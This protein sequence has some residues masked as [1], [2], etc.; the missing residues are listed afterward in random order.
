M[1]DLE[2]KNIFHTTAGL[3]HNNT[4][5]H[6]AGVVATANHSDNKTRCDIFMT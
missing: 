1:N 6:K 3:D 4:L 2:E 5:T